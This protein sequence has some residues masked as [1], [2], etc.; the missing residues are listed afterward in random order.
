MSKAPIQDIPT[1][2]C[3]SLAGQTLNVRIPRSERESGY[4]RTTFRGSCR[5]VGGT[6]QMA[7]VTC[8]WP[9]FFLR[10]VQDEYV[11]KNSV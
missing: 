8:F 11:Q 5:N 1:I 4:S 6:N 10:V 2:P 3:P 7:A 9:S